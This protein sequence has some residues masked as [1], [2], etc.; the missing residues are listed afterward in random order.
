VSERLYFAYGSNLNEADMRLRC[1]DARPDAVARLDGWRLTFHGVADIE[2]APGRTVHGLLWWVGEDDICGL[3]RYEGA[4]TL[5][6]QRTLEVETA[7]GR[8][9]AMAYV[10]VRPTYLGLPSPWYLERIAQG[11]RRWGLPLAEL[12]RAVEESRQ[13]LERAGIARYEPDGRK[14]L[15]A[16]L[17]EEA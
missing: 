6:A 2:P 1:P 15:R 13:A 14:R 3:D 12:K 7:H 11:Y 17:A 4:P 16:V 5:Y 9:W 8:R 10:M